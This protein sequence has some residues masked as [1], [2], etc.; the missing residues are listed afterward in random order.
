MFQKARQALDS[1]DSRNRQKSLLSLKLLH[2]LHYLPGN[3]KTCY[4]ITDNCNDAW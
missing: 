3:L 1:T 4:M 2:H